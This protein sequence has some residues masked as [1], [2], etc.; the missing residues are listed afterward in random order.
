MA[1][2]GV[3]YDV[4]IAGRKGEPPSEAGPWSLEVKRPG[5]DWQT[6]WSDD[7]LEHALGDALDMKGKG[8]YVALRLTWVRR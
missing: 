3:E 2:E 1:A 7:T 6:W 5:E 8:D 4:E